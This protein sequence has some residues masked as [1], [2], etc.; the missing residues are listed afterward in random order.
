VQ[1]NHALHIQTV[2]HGSPAHSA[3]FAPGDEWLGVELV[4]TRKH[5]ASAWR[6]KKLDQLP[7][8]LGTAKQCTA[9]V[10]RDNQLLRLPLRMPAKPATQWRL[11]LINPVKVGQWLADR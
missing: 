5:T 11:G 6:L 1:E 7:L 4:N 10:S 8:L 2:L 9:L 3:G